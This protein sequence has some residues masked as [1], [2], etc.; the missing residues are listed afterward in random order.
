MIYEATIHKIIISAGF[1][2]FKTKVRVVIEFRTRMWCGKEVKNKYASYVNNGV[3]VLVRIFCTY[4]AMS[5]R[6]VAVSG[7][8]VRYCRYYATFCTSEGG[9]ITLN[10][11]G[12]NCLRFETESC[13]KLCRVNN[14]NGILNTKRGAP[15]CADFSVKMGQV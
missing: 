5:K 3:R 6:I 1:E 13:T 8:V 12:Q 4:C 9:E 2:N 15:M 7:R 14:T 10:S 11:D